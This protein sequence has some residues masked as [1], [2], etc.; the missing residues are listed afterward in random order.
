M[1]PNGYTQAYA[2][3]VTLLPRLFQHPSEVQ[4]DTTYLKLK[5]KL[6]E[7]SDTFTLIAEHTKNMNIH[8]HGVIKFLTVRCKNA[9]KYFKDHFRRDKLFGFVDIKIMDDEDGWRDYIKKEFKETLD[10]INRRP[11]IV[12]GFNFFLNGFY[13]DYRQ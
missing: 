6:I 10:V 3:T 4:F 8:Y 7:L 9:I 12:D 5:D 13:K 2:F 1:A 11:I